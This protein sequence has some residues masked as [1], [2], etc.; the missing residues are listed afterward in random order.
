MLPSVLAFT[1]SAQSRA[2][3]AEVSLPFLI[4]RCPRFFCKES[5]FHDYSLAHPYRYIGVSPNYLIET[6]PFLPSYYLGKSI[7]SHLRRWATELAGFITLQ[8]IRVYLL[9]RHNKPINNWWAIED[10]NLEPSGY[11]PG[12][13]TV[14]LMA[15]I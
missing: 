5:V 8:A 6:L 14:E 10:L 4:I 13:L 9:M 1:C 7:S 2:E 12:A 15:L 3:Q 11:E